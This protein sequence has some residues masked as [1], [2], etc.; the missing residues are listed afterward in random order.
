MD[1]TRLQ[2][3]LDA[4]GAD[5]HRWPEPDRAVGANPVAD[6]AIVSL[7]DQARATDDLLERSLPY[8]PSHALHERVLASAPRPRGSRFRQAWWSWQAGVGA[9]L[10]A[11]VGAG[12]MV[13]WTVVAAPPGAD[14]NLDLALVAY[15][16]APADTAFGEFAD[17]DLG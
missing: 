15:A 4:Y 7:F 16:A 8:T 10:A 2:T 1:R 9:G 6:A 5:I 14:A 12:V 11:S 13:G 3:V 17:A